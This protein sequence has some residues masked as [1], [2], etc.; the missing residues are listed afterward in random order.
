MSVKNQTRTLLGWMLR[1]LCKYYLIQMYSLVSFRIQCGWYIA[2]LSLA[3]DD[4]NINIYYHLSSWYDNLCVINFVQ[5]F[6]DFVGYHKML[7]YFWDKII[8]TF[9]FFLYFNWKIKI[10]QHVHICRDKT[11]LTRTQH[12]RNC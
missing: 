4:C 9:D 5:T 1:C 10:L 3:W 8:Q 7:L 11:N 6:T 12:P 2:R